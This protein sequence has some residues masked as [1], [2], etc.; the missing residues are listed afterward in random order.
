MQTREAKYNKNI[1]SKNIIYIYKYTPC[2]ATTVKLLLSA[3]VSD[4]QDG[5]SLIVF[6]WATS[7]CWYT[8][9]V[10]HKTVTKTV[11]FKFEF[12]V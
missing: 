11:V 6:E 10:W 2:M 5:E 7:S 3:E 4:S 9:Y 8:S 12:S 1:F